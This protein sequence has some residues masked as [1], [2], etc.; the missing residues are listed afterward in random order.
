MDDT[1]KSRKKRLGPRAGTLTR[2]RFLKV[3]GA[4]V[5]AATLLP[6]RRARAQGGTAISLF[7]GK[8]NANPQAQI[9]VMETVKAAFERLHPGVTMTYDTYATAGE[10]LTKLETAAAAHEGPDVFEFGSTLVPTAYATGAFDVITPAMWGHL[11]GQAAFFK[12][13]LAMSGPSADRLIAVP[14]FANPFAMVYNT[15]MF[16]EAGIAKPPATWTEFVDTAKKLTVPGKNQWGTVVDPSDGFDPWH[17]VWLFATQLGGRLMDATGTKGLLDAPLVVEASSFW[18]DWMAK[19]QIAARAGA[20][21]RGPDALHAFANGQ[22]AMWVMQGPGA[23]PVLDKSPV[24][25]E[26]AWT[27]DPYVPYGMTGVPAGGKPAQGFVAGQYLCIFKYG[28]NKDLALDL[29]RLM[30]SPAIQYQFLTKFGQLPV[31]LRTFDAHPEAKQ[32]PWNIFYTAEQHAYPTP[33]FGSW[34]QLEVVVGHAINKIAAQIATKGSYARGDLKQAL[35]QAN[36]ELEA[37][38]KQHK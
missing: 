34:G 26:Y 8:F 16:K 36:A 15:R 1:G 6:A 27:P 31:T 7:V 22:A 38:L 23:I 25:K 9:Q 19:F 29:I 33:F 11:G 3:S 30:T 2:R 10:E 37:S 14:E 5:L 20:T 32:P 4:G 24:A 17:M 12:P 35:T 21:Y 13:Q 18:L 28:K